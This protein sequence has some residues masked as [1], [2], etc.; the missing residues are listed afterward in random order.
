MV[1]VVTDNFARDA[2]S[3]AEDNGMPTI[4]VA[5]VPSDEFYKRR[6]SL[7]EVRPVAAGAIG[8]FIDALTRPLEQ[9]EANPKP[10]QMKMARTTKIAGKNY[11]LALEKFNQLFLDNHW[12]DGFPLVPPTSE[13]VKWMLTGISRSPDEVIGTVA[14]KNGIATIEKIAINAVMAGAKP[15]YLPVIIAAME[16]LTDKNYDLLHVMTSTGSFNLAI[17]VTGPIAKDINMNSGIGF[18][19]HGWRANNTIGRAVRLTLINTGHLWPAE[20]DMALMGRSSSHTFYTFAEN[21]AVNPW[22]PYHVALGY[23]AEDSCVTVSTIGSYSGGGPTSY[24]GG[25]VTPWTAESILDNIVKDIILDRREWNAFRPGVAVPSASPSKH[26]LVVHP[27]FALELNR[28]GYT[29]EGVQDYLYGRTS[30]PYETL[31]PKEIEAIQ[32]GWTERSVPPDRRAVFREALKPDGKVPVLVSP[33]DVHIIVAGGVPGYS[34]GM[35]Y[36]RAAH[37]TKLIRGATLTKAGR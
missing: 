29:Q 3:S 6:I 33:K 36:F 4:R 13:R 37:E 10:K 5:T 35:S 18:L 25:A 9:G 34:F 2:K 7:K 27:E 19:G 20:N 22:K 8:T 26:I 14:P 17:I 31:S 1:Y 23:K 28:L 16:G 24:G 21:D 30:V 15:E 12:G 11:D 32:G